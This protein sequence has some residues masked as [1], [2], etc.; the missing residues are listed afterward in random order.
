MKYYKRSGMYKASNVSFNPET[1]E[2]YSYDWWLFV[3]KIGDC[4][5][6]NNYNYS[7]TT[8]KHQSKLRSL[9]DELGIKITCTIESP[10]GLQDLQ[11]T[12]DYYEVVIANLHAA[13]DK[14]RSHKSTNLK[15]QKQVQH[16]QQKIE[17][18]NQLIKLKQKLAA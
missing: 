8:S 2:A 16:Y 1:Y 18:V 14:P 12:I 10:K 13:I 5:V 15:R 6:F 7:N 3:C 17:E 11:S 9:L 4:I